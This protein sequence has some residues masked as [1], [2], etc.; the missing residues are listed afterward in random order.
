MSETS[1][2]APVHSTAP[3]ASSAWRRSAG[4]RRRW[5]VRRAAAARRLPGRP[6]HAARRATSAARRACCSLSAVKAVNDFDKCGYCML[7]PAYMDV[8][9]QPDERGIPSGK[10]CPQDALKRRVVGTR[11]PGRPEQQL[12]RVHGR[13]DAVRRLRQVR[14]GV[15]AA[16]R[17]RLAAP[18]DPLR[19][20][21]RVQR[22]RDPG[23]LPRR[24]RS[25]ACR[26][27]AV[28]RPDGGRA[29][30]CLSHPARAGARGRPLAV[31]RSCS[32]AFASSALLRAVPEG[33]AGLRR[34]LLAFRR[35]PTPS[36][37]SGVAPAS[38]SPCSWRSA[39]PGRLARPRA[40]QPQRA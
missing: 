29:P 33:A 19:P 31:R 21:R 32:L 39:R 3:A 37:A 4:P 26:R 10:V 24:A 18:R 23:R 40:P 27:R 13:R 5:R 20:L 15:Q 8:T 1:T 16:G 30:R 25:C 7:C 9:S 34:Q 17:Q 14:E 28:A 12:L 22:V 11:G 35:R 6:A 36:R 2:T 38:T